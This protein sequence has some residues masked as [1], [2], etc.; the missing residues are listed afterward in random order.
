MLALFVAV[1]LALVI[2]LAVSVQAWTVP[3]GTPVAADPAGPV[4]THSNASGG[5]G[6]PFSVGCDACHVPHK[7][8]Y[9]NLLLADGDAICTSCHDTGPVHSDPATQLAASAATGGCITCHP[10]S[11]GFMPVSGP[12]TLTISKKSLGYDDL[13]ADGN[14]SPGDRVHYRIDYGNPGPDAATGVS[15]SDKP[16]AAYVAMIEAISGSGTY[17]GTVIQW[18]L[19]T[20]AAGDSGSVTYDVLLQDGTTFGGTTTTTAAVGPVDVANDA[21]LVADGRQPVTASATVSVVVSGTS[22]TTST[23]VPPGDTTTTTLVTGDS[24]TT[25]TASTTTTTASTTTTTLLPGPADLV[26]TA[27]LSADNGAA[28]SKQVV[29]PVVVPGVSSAA[30]SAALTALDAAVASGSSALTLDN[31]AVGFDDLDANGNLSPG[32]RV[33]YRVDYGNPGTADLT[34]ALLRV[35]LD[36]AHV[37]T[38]EGV[39]DGGTIETNAATNPSAAQWTIG[40]LAAGASGFVTYGVVLWDAAAV[41]LDGWIFPVEG[42]NHFNDDFGAPRYVGGYHPHAGID[43]VCSRGTPLV[44]VVG[45]VIRH[46]NPV[47]TGLGGITVWLDGDDGNSYYYAHLSDIQ[48]GILPGTRVAAGQVVGFAGDSG[49]AKGGVVHLH[50]EIHPGGGDVVDPY[51]VLKGVLRVS[52]VPVTTFDTTT[53]TTAVTDTTTTSGPP[54]SDT[55]TTSDTTSTSDTTVT[56]DTTTTSSPTVTSDTT[57]TSDTTSTSDTTTTSDPTATTDTTTTTAPPASDTT[58][59]TA[60][61]APAAAPLPVAAAAVTLAPLGVLVRRRSP[62]RRR[63]RR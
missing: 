34:G 27:T 17:D 14:L 57:T 10:H 63:P 39:G 51:L 35:D 20:L 21:A 53:T 40:T 58:T 42:Q 32:D 47:D 11:S 56:S 50:F 18:N 59:T 49:D 19:G 1:S 25:T 4:K 43:I 6:Q 2:G 62:K 26:N 55:T 44:A 22:A 23:T 48:E 13:D 33:Y 28:V 12:V 5:S 41:E 16:D 3:P 52:E 31:V 15:L 54:T 45:G 8:P 7:A 60:G 24:T 36:T 29:L 38:V 37:A 30:P 61:P 9:A 46:A